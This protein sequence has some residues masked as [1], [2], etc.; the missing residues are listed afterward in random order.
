MFGLSAPASDWRFDNLK[1]FKKYW[2][3]EKA[4]IK[5]YQ[6]FKCEII[7]KLSSGKDFVLQ[8]QDVYDWLKKQEEEDEKSW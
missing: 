7:V 2:N 5:L 6:K 3:S 1:V 8:A 4:A